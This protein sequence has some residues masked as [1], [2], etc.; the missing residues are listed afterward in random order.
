MEF[1]ERL[2]LRPVLWAQLHDLTGN[3]FQEF[4]Q[5]VM[6]LCLPGFVD[7]RTHGNKGDLASDGL[8]LHNG[9]LYA[10]YAPETSDA[11]AVIRKFKSDL[12]GALNK[13]AGQF[14][15]FVFVHNDV[16]GVHPEIASALAEA[17]TE[18]PNLQ[19]EVMGVRHFRDL[20]GQKDRHDVEAIV[21]M[22]LPLHYEV[23]VGLEEMGELLQSIASRRLVSDV[24]TPVE[25]V[26]GKKLRYSDLSNETQS[27]LRIGMRYSSVID[28]YY[29]DRIDIAE[30][31]EV[32]ARFQ[33]E[34]L[35]ATRATSD[36]EE[37]L[38]RLRIFLAGS[39]V[40]PAA[41][42]RA[43]T[44]VLAYFFQSCDIFENAPV[45]WPE[46]TAEVVGL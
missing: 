29:K 33:V 22:Q 14:T 15:T 23:T 45:G 1:Y 5:D 26:S 34:Y 37:R 16:R 30:R 18:H 3:A 27:E 38:V 46:P 21:K 44:A 31:D 39:R 32:A 9:K 35:D 11:V 25:A 24:T 13:R 8:D 17:R 10:C 43:Q 7:V 12:A 36:P 42:Y 40:T 2:S 6:A 20:L 28:G 41:D 4:F 19:F